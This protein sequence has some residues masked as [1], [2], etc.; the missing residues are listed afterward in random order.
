M[1]RG[2]TIFARMEHGVSMK[3]LVGRGGEEGPEH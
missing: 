3:I 1:G 2:V